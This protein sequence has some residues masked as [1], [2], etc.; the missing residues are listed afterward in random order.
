MGLSGDLI[1]PHNDFGLFFSAFHAFAALEGRGS[2]HFRD[3]QDGHSF[4]L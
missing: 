2:F 3:L 1:E 4:G